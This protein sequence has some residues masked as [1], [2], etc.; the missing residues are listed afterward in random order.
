VA[1]DCSSLPPT[2]AEDQL[3]GHDKGAF[4][5][6]DREKPGY[7]EAADGGTLFLDEIG[8]LLPELQVKFLRVLEEGAIVRVGSRTVRPVDVRFVAATNRDLVAE[9]EKGLFRVDLLHRLDA[10][11]V[12]VPPLR[13]RPSEI[14]PLA[15]LFVARFSRML[16]KDE[17]GIAPETLALL[18]GYEWPGNVRELRNVIE[19]A[20]TLCQGPLLLPEDLPAK[21][22]GAARAAP[23]T[24]AESRLDASAAGSERERIIAALE[25]CAWNQTQAAA[26]LDMPLRTLVNRLDKYQVPRPRKKHQT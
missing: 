7:F 22:S 26:R 17:P 8:E 20:V 1:L 2:L 12:E 21:V 11:V 24:R 5:G 23:L 4:S 6:A 10:L 16:E 15:E 19:R 14:E 9:A 18:R 13:Q 3:F 25:A